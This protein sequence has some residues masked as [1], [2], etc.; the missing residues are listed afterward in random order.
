MWKFTFILIGFAVGDLI[1]WRWLDGQLRRLRRP[2]TWR[3]MLGAFLALQLSYLVWLDLQVWWH[4]LPDRAPLHWGVAAYL[5]HVAVMPLTVAAVVIAGSVTGIVKQVTRPTVAPPPADAGPA[6]A[7]PSRRQV[8][9]AALGAA[10]PAF[11][12]LATPKACGRLKDFRVRRHDLV[13][14]SLPT[15]LD[16]LTIAHVT[17][18][19]I[20]RFLPRG[21]L[22]RV[23]DAT[24]DLHAD[25]IALTGDLNDISQSDVEPALDF[26]RRLDPRSGVALIEGN[27]DVMNGCEH[28]EKAMRAAGAPLL[29]DEAR[30]FTV[31]G[32]SVP[33]QFLGIAWGTK[34][35]GRDLGRVGEEA[36]RYYREYGTNATAASLDTVGA[37]RD[38]GAFPILLAHHPHA[39][40]AAASRGGYPLVLA[41]HTHGGQLMLNDRV[42]V[43]PLRFRYW[44]GEYAKG[45]GRLFV[46]N[47]IGNWFP[48][49]INAPAEIVHL[50]LRRG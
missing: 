35:L 25:F 34:R 44:S 32:R 37:A 24:N 28:Y 40:D 18:L 23:A 47:G 22:A 4:G 46:S 6:P 31:T 8:L 3:V 39:F 36:R 41:G 42:G 38:A 5:W 30:S 9:A 7:A 29:L 45:D 26:L 33:V 15:P 17:D 14:S 19:H 27:H 48:L 11:T 13:I 21:A 12:C 1:F 2:M 50:T 16:G 10:P 20:G 49:R 43:G